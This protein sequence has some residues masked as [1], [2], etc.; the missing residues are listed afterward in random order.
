MMHSQHMQDVH[1]Q[2]WELRVSIVFQVQD[3]YLEDGNDKLK[4]LVLLCGE[5][6]DK[7]QMAAAGGLAMLTAIQKKICTKLTKVVCRESDLYCQVG[8]QTQLFNSVLLY[9]YLYKGKCLIRVCFK[10]ILYK[11]YPQKFYSQ[12]SLRNLLTQSGRCHRVS[13]G[14]YCK[15]SCFSKSTSNMMRGDSL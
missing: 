12:L 1:V 6:D 13:S 15:F 11:K 4:L 5:D 14:D 2:M 3:R 10:S 7:L 9:V 8:F